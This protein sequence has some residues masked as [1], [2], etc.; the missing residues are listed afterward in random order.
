MPEM[1]A[2]TAHITV[3]P[4]LLTPAAEEYTLRV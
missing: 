3:Q 4:V 2:I 1:F